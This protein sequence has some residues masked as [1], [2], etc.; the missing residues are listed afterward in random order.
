MIAG[1]EAPPFNVPGGDI[2]NAPTGPGTLNPA[3]DTTLHLFVVHAHSHSFEVSGV[4]N[5]V[6]IAVPPVT[7]P[8]GSAAVTWDKVTVTAPAPVPFVFG[9][10]V[11]AV[12]NNTGLVGWSDSADGWPSANHCV[13]VRIFGFGFT[14]AG[15]P[16]IGFTCDN[17]DPSQD[18]GVLRGLTAGHGYFLQVVPAEGD[19]GH[20]HQIPGTD[21]H[22]GIDVFTTR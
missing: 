5:G 2:A 21:P 8:T 6:A 16:H 4:E 17:G 10:H 15:S 18:V 22:G 12:D 3:G 11:I 9:G 13:E 14:T 7:P 20:H 19:Y 1:I